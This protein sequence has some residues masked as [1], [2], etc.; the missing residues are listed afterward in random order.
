MKGFS[1]LDSISSLICFG[2]ADVREQEQWAVRGIE[3]CYRTGF[4]S[5]F[6]V[7]AASFFCGFMLE[8]GGRAFMRARS[9]GLLEELR[10]QWRLMWRERIDDKVSAEGIARQDYSLLSMERGTVVVA[11]RQYKAPDFCQI[12][13]QQR[14]LLGLEL[15]GGCVDPYVGGW[16]KFI[17]STLNKHQHVA[18]RKV[19]EPLESDGGKALQRKKG[20]RG[21]VHLF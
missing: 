21:W 3:L 17:R 10:V 19:R 13:E 16:G 6:Y 8:K 14:R 1:G 7:F 5:V 2:M 4:H 9:E 12:L 20:G 15:T 11:T 18:N